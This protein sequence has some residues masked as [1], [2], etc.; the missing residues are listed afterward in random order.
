MTAT[1]LT[2]RVPRSA[3]KHRL[4]ASSVAPVASG[5]ERGRVGFTFLASELLEAVPMCEARFSRSVNVICSG[6]GL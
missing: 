3:A 1:F 5:Y 6:G 4:A 2:A